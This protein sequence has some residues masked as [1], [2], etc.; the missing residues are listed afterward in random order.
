MLNG[1]K[2]YYKNHSYYNRLSPLSYVFVFFIDL[3]ILIK[4]SFKTFRNFKNFRDTKSLKN[5][6]KDQ[7]AFVFANGPSLNKVD[8]NKVK[9]LQQNSGNKVICVNSFISKLSHKLIPD[10]YVI[11]DPVYFGF[12]QELHSKTV[13]KDVKEDLDL[14]EKYNVTVFIPLKFKNNFKI[15]T[16]IYYFNDMEIRRFNRNITDITKP[17]SYL[18]MTAY[19]AL[20][21][22]YYLGFK[23]I[24]ISGYDNNYFKT[25]EVDKNNKIYYNENH[26]FKQDDNNQYN[27]DQH[28]SLNMKLGKFLLDLSYLF[29][30]LYKFPKNII[31]LDE[32][33]LV[34]SFVKE[35][36]FKN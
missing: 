15:N 8:L 2:E 19:K 24:Y 5:T 32:E 12:D 27:I 25:I 17:R 31:N 34:D 13:Y 23:K 18:S 35:N 28:Y 10:Y 33:S 14:I 21:I 29:L 6:F 9:Q 26:A 30:D 11:S 1:L 3:I 22:A 7:N 20:A 36:I 16:K 4:T